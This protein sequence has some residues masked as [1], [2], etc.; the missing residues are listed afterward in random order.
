MGDP[1]AARAA[2]PALTAPAAH[3]TTNV[4]L[5]LDGDA[6]TGQCSTGGWEET[7]LPGWTITSADPVIDC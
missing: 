4:N 6:E 5:P 2:L 7:T 3:A 1:A